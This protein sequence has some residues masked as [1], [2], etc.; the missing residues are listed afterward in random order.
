MF[1]GVT[2]FI[3][4]FI[5]G[6]FWL[7][8]VIF[9]I[10]II[11]ANVPEG[12]LATVT[13]CLTLTAKRMAKKNCLVKNLEAVETLGSTST[14]CSDKTGTLTEEGLSLWGVIP[15][16]EAILD[17]PTSSVQKL[18]RE[19][20]LVSCLAACH[21][22]ITIDGQLSGDPLDLKMFEATGWELVEG[23]SSE[24]EN[25]DQMMPT[26]VRP[27][28]EP[29][30]EDS[31]KLALEIGIIRQFTFTSN[32]ARM[33]VIAKKLR[34][35]QFMVLVKGA[36]ERL[37]PLCD[38]KSLP[39]DFSS[40]LAT[41]ANS[42]YRVVAVAGK[43]LQVNFLKVQKITRE[44]AEKDLVFLG[45][46]VMQNTLKPESSGVIQELRSAS[47][48]CLMVTGDNLLTAVSVARYRVG[49]QFSLIPTSVSQT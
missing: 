45:F 8:A 27:K 15:C 42:G 49:Q 46:L 43:N 41:L 31:W 30:L 32:L 16:N 19:S 10:G 9:L 35:S 3:I 38:P 22:L 20:M 26:M 25:Y 34:S 24:N 7:D 39:S 14:I 29:D 23:G 33:S 13:V 21:S 12:L 40:Q 37:E 47:L 2:F 11:V 5:L 6:Y 36:P 44:E 48:R 4:A 17:Q 1:L 28:P 18:D